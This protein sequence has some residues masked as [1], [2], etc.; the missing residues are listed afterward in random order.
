H[1]HTLPTFE[2]ALRAL[3]AGRYDAV[4][5]Q[6]LVAL[7]L[8][9]ETGLVNLKV[10]NRPID[11]FRQDFCFAVKEGDRGTL[12]LLNEGLALVMADGTYRHLH[13]KWF[14]AL[15]LP[16][17]R[18]IIVGGDHN[19][20][21]YEYLDEKGRPAGYNVELTRAIAREMGL[22]IEIRL[23]PWAEIV[24]ALEKGEIDAI[25]GMF[26]SPVRDLKF[27]FTQPHAVNHYVG[28]VRKGEGDPPASIAELKGKSIVLQRGDIIHNYLV[29]NGLGDHVSLVETQEDVLLELAEGRY[30]CA[31]AVR[32]SSLHLIEK[33]RWNNLVLGYRPFVSMEY[34]YAVPNNHKALLAQ[35]SEGLKVLEENG[36]YRRIHEKWLGVYKEDPLSLI[37]ALRYLVMVLIPLALLFLGFFL[38]SWFLRR[39]V[40]EKT[41]DLQ[42]SAEFQRA[43]I[44]CSPVALYSIDLTGKVLAWNASAERIFG[45]TA[46]E[47]MGKPLPI[48]PADKEEEFAGLRKRVIES[49]GFSGAEVVRQRKDGILFDVSLSAAPICDASGEMVAIMASMS[50]IT[51][52]KN[53]EAALRE[54][55]AKYR[56]LVENQ[57]DLVVKV[58]AEG[59]FLFISPSYC[60]MF[61]KKEEELLGQEFMPL[62]HEEDRRPTDEAMKALSSPPHTAYIEQRA[63]TKKG[64][65]WLAWVDTAVLDN[66]G[67][68]KEIIGVGRDITE[69]KHAEEMLKEAE[70]LYRLHF[71][72]VSDIIYSV[73]RE[74]KVVNIS[75]SVETVLGYKPEDIIG[76]PFPD[77]NL[78][79]PEYLEK[80][81][82]DTMRILE[83]ERI[84][85]AEYQFIARD[86]TKKWGEVSGAP[87]IREG[88]VVA[89]ISVA[90]DITDRKRAE[91]ER[92]KL[93]AQLMQAQKMEAVGALAGGVAHD[94]NN[95]LG[96]I[97]GNAEL[98]MGRTAPEDPLRDDLKEIIDAARRSADI[99]RQLLAFARK[100]TI[101]PEVLDL[102]ETVEG[103]LKMLRRL[104]GEDIDLSWRPG[105]GLWPVK[106]DPSQIDQILAN[107]LVNARDAIGGVG[108]ITIETGKAAF[109]EAYC[110]DHAGFVP[111]EFVLL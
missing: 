85:S 20:P 70:S 29:K 61:G 4:V 62:V 25:Q 90:R 33:K 16:S 1:I 3:S 64:W 60:R 89:V 2:E 99:T 101:A 105:R 111:G 80:A 75:P 42:E 38:W 24:Q 53:A 67:N 52:R 104:I 63:M 92:E 49:G 71:E 81:A 88:Q 15:E 102:N 74:L 22:D 11:G 23:A 78:L 7:R 96:V 91:E 79:A 18:R 47:V 46:E 59:R 12:A 6:R 93:N 35:F 109:D 32:I 13:A 39:Q 98:A 95:M 103:M 27:D 43:M 8:I 30:D 57:T 17:N 37:R 84:R 48:V 50:D 9:Q 68:V 5:I 55:E 10:I 40:A 66:R 56:L 100:Q 45:W 36:E 44:A 54:S 26:Y 58:D 87:L 69:R 14:A 51:E 77:L 108:K 106:M 31:L 28:V 76:R 97:M 65:L 94:Y 82:F 86:G 41:R 34:C 110:A 19:Y 83:G 21:P 107:L 72:N 73:D